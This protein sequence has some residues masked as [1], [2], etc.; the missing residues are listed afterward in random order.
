M[1][2]T[3]KVIEMLAKLTVGIMIIWLAFEIAR[4]TSRI[5]DLEKQSRAAQPHVEL[6]EEWKNERS[7]FPVNVEL[8]ERETML[9]DTFAT[10]LDTRRLT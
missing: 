2:V 6:L 7:K 10:W 9:L 8:I 4:N 5:E 3:L 1:D